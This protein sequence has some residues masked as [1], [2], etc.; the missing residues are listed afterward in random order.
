MRSRHGEVLHRHVDAVAA[1]GHQGRL[2]AQVGQVGAGEARVRAATFSASVSG[3]RV[4]FFMCTQDGDAALLVG[5]V[6]QH[7]AVEAAGAQQRRVEHFGAVGGG[8]QHQAGGR[9]EA[10]QLDQQLVEG[11]LL[12]VVAAHAAE[13]AAGAAHGVEFVDED[14]RRGLG[15]GLLEEVAHPRGADAD[16]HLDELGAGDR[17]EG[18]A[19]LA[20]HRLGQ[21]GLAG[22][23]RADQQH[24]LGHPAAEAAVGFRVLQEADDFLQL[25][26]GL[27]HA[28][29]VVEAHAGVGFHI[30]LGL[31]LAEV[32]EAAAHALLAGEL[33]HREDPD[34]HEDHRRQHPAEHVLE[35]GVLD[36]AGEL[37]VVLGRSLAS[38]GSTRVVTNFWRPSCSGVLRVPWMVLSAIAISL[39]SPAFTMRWNSL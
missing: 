24:A 30:D 8:Q 20:G 19:G 18:H 27:I 22:A 39:T 35:Q 10:V 14:D 12:L 3:G 34:P 15:P 31:A 17:E 25:V 21:Q 11:L 26:L 4:I 32:H 37:H 28:G 1:G 29:H 38:A 13:G 2:V 16:E 23:R 6:H 33:A 9:I 36:D 5:A 7:L